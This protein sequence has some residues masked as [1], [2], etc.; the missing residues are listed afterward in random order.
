MKNDWRIIMKPVST[1]TG[2][3]FIWQVYRLRNRYAPDNQGNREVFDAYLT[4]DMAELKADELNRR[5]E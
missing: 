2:T 3:G 5:R 1:S 4:R